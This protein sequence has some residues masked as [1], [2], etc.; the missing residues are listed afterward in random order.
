MGH[1]SFFDS[2]HWSLPSFVQIL[3]EERAHLT[4]EKLEKASFCAW[5]STCDLGLSGC[6]LVAQKAEAIENICWKQESNSV[7]RKKKKGTITAVTTDL[8]QNKSCLGPDSRTAH[9]RV[10]TSL[11]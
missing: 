4:E 7:Y 5:V 8:P 6:K 10:L 1:W 3:T 2:Q 9:G 11:L